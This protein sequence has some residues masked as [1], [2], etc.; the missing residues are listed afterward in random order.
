VKSFWVSKPFGCWKKLV[1]QKGIA[2]GTGNIA[3]LFSLL[4]ALAACV[5]IA[6]AADPTATAT[7]AATTPPARPRRPDIWESHRPEILADLKSGDPQTVS[8]GIAELRDIAAKARDHREKPVQML[9]DL[10]RYDDAESV[11]VDLILQDVPDTNFFGAVERL[12]AQA[13]LAQHKYPEALSAARSYYDVASLKD[14]S[15]AI[16]LVALALVFGKP[17]DPTAAKRFKKQQIQ[18]A[19]SAPTS[20][21]SQP[22]ASALDPAALTAVSAYST[23]QPTPLPTDSLGDPV[24]PTIPSDSKPFEATAEAID[25]DNYNAFVRKGN[26]L[27]LAGHA[28]EAHGLFDR[29]EAIAPDKEAAHAIE[30]VARSIRAESGC[31]GPANAYILQRRTQQQQ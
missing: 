23:S 9:I 18:W 6:Q 14:S 31:V 2:V 27:L 20:P 7:P 13:F 21:A 10:K 19:A 3:S 26:L 11:G 22:T 30:N 5:S 29:A 1:R 8:A 16:N 12:R 15:E 4:L 28:K 25:P 24:L 17:D